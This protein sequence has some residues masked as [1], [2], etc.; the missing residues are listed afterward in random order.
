LGEPGFWPLTTFKNRLFKRHG[1]DGLVSEGDAGLLR[2][3]SF[4]ARI[5]LLAGKKGLKK[6]WGGGRHVKKKERESF[7]RESERDVTDL[8]D[9][10][11]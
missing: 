9:E 1:G 2:K 4:F 8:N 6:M 11:S 3:A 7:L 5:S 10:G